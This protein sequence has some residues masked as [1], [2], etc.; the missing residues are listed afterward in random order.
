VVTARAPSRKKILKVA[1]V[2][3]AVGPKTVDYDMMGPWAVV[4]ASEVDWDVQEDK[5]TGQHHMPKV[6]MVWLAVVLAHVHAR[7]CLVC[8]SEMPMLIPISFALEEPEE[9]VVVFH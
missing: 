7:Y 9:S 8:Y 5:D 4:D 1:V 3:G 2:Q 6:D